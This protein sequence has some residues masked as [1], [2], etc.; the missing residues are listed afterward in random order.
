MQRPGCQSILC[1]VYGETGNASR[2]RSAFFADQ[3]HFPGA[4]I[5]AQRE[6]HALMESLGREVWS[7][8]NQGASIASNMMGTPL[9]GGDDR[10]SRSTPRRGRGTALRFSFLCTLPAVNSVERRVLMRRAVQ[11]KSGVPN[12]PCWSRLEAR[13]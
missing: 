11:Y 9:P 2:V 12:H 13:L 4:W 5:P 6:T 8:A 1:L 3:T 7:Q 10:M